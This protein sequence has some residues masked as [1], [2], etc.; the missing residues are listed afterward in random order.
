[1]KRLWFYCRDVKP[2]YSDLYISRA[3]SVS[4]NFLS[5]LGICTDSS[6]I[7]S[8]YTESPYLKL[9]SWTKY[10]SLSI[11]VSLSRTFLFHNKFK[12]NKTFE[13]TCIKEILFSYEWTNASE[14]SD[15]PKNISTWIKIKIFIWSLFILG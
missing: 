6:Q 5:S 14:L 4:N 15:V 2:H 3:I 8:F 11:F 13:R 12:V 10:R 1:M 9:P 7:Y